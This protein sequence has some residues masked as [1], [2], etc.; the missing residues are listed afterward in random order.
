MIVLCSMPRKHINYFHNSLEGIWPKNV[1]V[2]MIAY[3]YLSYHYCEDRRRISDVF[4][5]KIIY[6][7]LNIGELLSRVYEHLDKLGSRAFFNVTAHRQNMKF[8]RQILV[9]IG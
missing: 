9:Y 6:P 1:N 8:I 5:F 7:E 4:L 3:I 2:I